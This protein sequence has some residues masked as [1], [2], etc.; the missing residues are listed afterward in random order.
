M[1]DERKMYEECKVG[2]VV[3][4]DV[5]DFKTGV[6]LCSKGHV[7]TEETLSWIRKFNV[8]DIYIQKDDWGKVWNINDNHIMAYTKCMSA[9]N[10]VLLQVRTG[11]EVDAQSIKAIRDVFNGMLND[12]STIMGCVNMIKEIKSYTCAHSMNV[13]M[14]AVLL[15]KW[16]HLS[17]V[18]C[19]ELFYAGVL[20]D[21]GKYRISQ[22]VLNKRGKITPSELSIMKS[23]AQLSYDTVS[24]MSHISQDVKEGIW[25]HHERNDGTGY[26]RQLKHDQISMYSKILAVVDVYDAMISERVYKKKETPFTV[27][28]HLVIQ[29]MGRLDPQI[30]MTFLKNIADYYVGVKVKLST[31]EQAEVVFIPSQCVYRPIVKVGEDYL[32]LCQH[33]HIKIVDIL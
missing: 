5:V 9:L 2:D 6:V 23:H 1:L 31:H 30:L 28:E 3:A 32:D 19:E 20:H 14:L 4:R 10:Q 7:L 25:G 17:E 26:P 12:N 11:K 22:D 21:V 24:M 15:G 27:M 8:F 29:E 18:Q 13:G 33:K 16:L